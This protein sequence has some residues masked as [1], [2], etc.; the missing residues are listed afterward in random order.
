MADAV[1]E[2]VGNVSACY[3]FFG[4][5]GPDETMQGFTN[6][7]KA[8]SDEDKKQLTEGIQNGSMTY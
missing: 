7:W 2:K 6:E 4:K 5:G 1:K 3:R 8:L